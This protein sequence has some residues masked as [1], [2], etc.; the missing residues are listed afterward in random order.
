MAQ[1]HGSRTVQWSDIAAVAAA[2]L[3]CGLVF[4]TGRLL[5]PDMP[6]GPYY[7]EWSG[8][9]AGESAAGPKVVVAAVGNIA[10]PPGPLARNLAA[11][12]FVRRGGL[13][14]LAV[15]ASEPAASRVTLLAFHAPDGRDAVA[16]A[17]H[18]GD[19]LFF[20]RLRADRHGLHSPPLRVWD[21]LAAAG[22]ADTI[23]IATAG[24]GRGERCVQVEEVPFCGIGRTPGDGWKL[25]AGDAAG[26]RHGSAAVGAAWLALLLLPAGLL[27]RL[28]VAALLLVG[29]AWYLGIRLPVDTIF[30]RATPVELG[31]AA[32]GLLVGT[33]IGWL[34]LSRRPEPAAGTVLAQ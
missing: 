8:A 26:S 12:E 15:E 34:L 14:L 31:G 27:A 19:V 5:E 17:I 25:L 23:R 28:P 30:L 10:T 20:Q 21:A 18:G 9:G 29:V 24:Q 33:L 11:T 1:E 4:L 6:A 7:V 22:T 16:I 32:A 3:A 2:V 13:L